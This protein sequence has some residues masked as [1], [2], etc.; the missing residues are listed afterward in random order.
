[1]EEGGGGGEDGIFVLSIFSRINVIC[2]SVW[3]WPVTLT[4]MLS[5]PLLGCNV[6]I[7]HSHWLEFIGYQW[8]YWL[9]VPPPSKME[10]FHLFLF[11]GFPYTIG[12]RDALHLKQVQRLES[13]VT[14]HVCGWTI[15]HTADIIAV[16]AIC[17]HVRQPST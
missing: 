10:D 4:W 15:F 6:D 13:L 3:S 7:L 11:E 8:S 2:L 17:H 9:Y 5:I 14:C 12:P 16:I 1:M